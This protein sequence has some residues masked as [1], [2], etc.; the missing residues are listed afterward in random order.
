MPRAFLIKKKRA[1][2]NAVATGEGEANN[3]NS[4]VQMMNSLTE[5][6]ENLKELTRTHED[7][8]R[9]EERR[10]GESKHQE[11]MEEEEVSADYSSCDE[12]RSSSHHFSGATRTSPVSE[13]ESERHS[14]VHDSSVQQY[15]TDLSLKSTSSSPTLTHTPHRYALISSSTPSPH[16]PHHHSPVT[17]RSVVS[18][19]GLQ[20]NRSQP[21]PLPKPC[22]RPS[23][24]S[25]E[26]LLNHHPTPKR[27]YSPT[28]PMPTS[29]VSS[30]FSPHGY[31]TAPVVSPRVTETF[32]RRS[33]DDEGRRTG[34]NTHS[35]IPIIPSPSKYTPPCLSVSTWLENH[36]TTSAM[37]ASAYQKCRNREDRVSTSSSVEPES[38]SGRESA[39]C[40]PSPL[41]LRRDD[42]PSAFR[43]NDM[44]QVKDLSPRRRDFDMMKATSPRI[45]SPR[46][47]DTSP[48][49][50]RVPSTSPRDSV[51]ASPHEM[52]TSRGIHPGALSLS[53]MGELRR[54]TSTSPAHSE[55]TSSGCGSPTDS[56][57][58]SPDQPPRYPA[59]LPWGHTAS[60]ASPF[61]PYG[62]PAQSQHPFLPMGLRYLP[63]LPFPGVTK[64]GMSDPALS[65]PKALSDGITSAFRSTRPPFVHPAAAAYYS[66]LRGSM[67]YPFGFPSTEGVAKRSPVREVS[68]QDRLEM[69]RALKKGSFDPLAA[70]P[71][72]TAPVSLQPTHI[73][74]SGASVISPRLSPGSSSSARMEVTPGRSPDLCELP[75]GLS[76]VGSGVR[77]LALER[78]SLKPRS[79]EHEPVRYQCEACSKSYS[80]FSGLSKHKQFHCSAQ[81]KKEFSCKYCDK[82]YV[83]L[84]ALKMHIR[85]HTLPCKC[86]VCGKAFSRPWLLQGHLR[87][88]TGE[89]PFSCQHCARAFADR[90]NLRAHLQTHSDVKKYSCRHCS[91]TFSR[92]SLLLKHEDGCVANSV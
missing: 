92:M 49:D 11:E 69:L 35:Q 46:S 76:G 26:F 64:P 7:S 28:M 18:E 51:F 66:S 58:G 5:N 21:Q 40:F 91:K 86:N 33:G 57:E 42:G 34:T 60:S 36:H 13:A 65:Y 75:R 81:V 47:N 30:A 82:T 25:T 85:T 87:T 53:N 83:S 41:G 4:D 55:R 50:R 54:G 38:P 10:T 39:R 12:S 15:P 1:D 27:R 14:L 71:S 32:E 61:L 63:G 17:V 9:K 79:K 80:T 2:A 88:H 3:N 45:V 6:K 70:F 22:K 31:P 56:P 77:G 84:G 16:H 90:S 67:P 24:F 43:R 44:K 37:V 19:E 52:L 29:V 78:G 48:T 62:L 68:D 89:K 23:D 8:G 20:T 72:P 74:P 59:D 73:V